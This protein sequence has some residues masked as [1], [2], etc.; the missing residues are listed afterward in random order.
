MAF[1]DTE[2]HTFYGLDAPHLAS[3]DGMVVPESAVHSLALDGVTA[4]VALERNLDEEA[5]A[6]KRPVHAAAGAVAVGES[7]IA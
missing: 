1:V 7:I 5:S 6:Q 4:A 2:G 3:F